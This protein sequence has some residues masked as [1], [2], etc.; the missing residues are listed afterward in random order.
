MIFFPRLQENCT[1][2]HEHHK[3]HL[4][5]TVNEMQATVFTCSSSVTTSNE[6]FT[7]IGRKYSLISMH[8]LKRVKND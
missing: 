6:M 4:L 8:Y 1:E 5:I 7:K 2:V 3:C